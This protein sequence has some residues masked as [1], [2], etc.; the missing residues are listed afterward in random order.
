MFNL[1]LKSGM[2]LGAAL[3][4]GVED[5]DLNDCSLVS[6]GK[7]ARIQRV[8][9]PRDVAGM[10]REHLHTEGIRTGAVFLG[11]SAQLSSRQA[12]YRFRSALEEHASQAPRG[13]LS[14]SG[15]GGRP[16]GPGLAPR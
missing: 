11:R 3:N 9:F 2:R 1:L 8:E 14:T 13:P 5:L 12:Q 16:S 15:A 10:I 4:V 6:E 7:H